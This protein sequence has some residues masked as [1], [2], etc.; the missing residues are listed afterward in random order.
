M[1]TIALAALVLAASVLGPRTAPAQPVPC[2]GKYVLDP[3]LELGGGLDPARVVLLSRESIATGAL[4]VFLGDPALFGGDSC[5]ATAVTQVQRDD[6]FVVKAKFEGCGER[7]R[8]RI[9]LRFDEACENVTVGRVRSLGQVLASFT[10]TR[11]RRGGVTPIDPNDP[12]PVDPD[13]PAPSDPDAP[14]PVDPPTPPAD[15]DNTQPIGTTPQISTLEPLVAQRG[16]TISLF[17][18]NLD[19]DANG[20]TWVAPGATPPYV[21]IFAREDVGLGSLTVTPTF[22]SPERIDVRVPSLAV[23]GTL[24]LAAR[25][26]F[27][28]ET[29]AETVDRLVVVTEEPPAANVPQT[30]TAPATTNRGTLTVQELPLS[31]FDAGTFQVTGAGQQI[32]AFLD[33]NDDNVVNLF[34]TGRDDVPYLAFPVRSSEFDFSIEGGRGYFQGS[35]A[36]LWVFFEGGNPAVLDA[37]DRF[38]VVHLA[39][40][41]AART[42]RPIAMLA[43]VA[44]SPGVVMMAD[45]FASE[46]S[47]TVAQPGAGVG[48]ISGHIAAVPLFLE[49]IFLPSQ[50]GLC[51]D[52]SPGC[53]FPP[54]V[55]QRLW[56]NGI[57]IDFDVPLFADN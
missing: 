6:A 34:Q 38:F 15:D 55:E 43:G 33:T 9:R 18:S 2:V 41:L 21:V 48:A 47:I 5:Q 46:T 19:R 14:A 8:F 51:P 44:G 10:A 57:V 26:G 35:N 39:I 13:A 56:G 45:Q 7:P 36:I 12:A 53:D 30:G 24:R 1:R 17:G 27:R 31:L 20:N 49:N 50:P 40:D 37:S 4:R 23:S 11:A 54:S 22:V 42:A 25:S 3:S 52:G 16:E 32:G 28:L 29:L